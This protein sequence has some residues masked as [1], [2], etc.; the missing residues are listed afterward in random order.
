MGHHPGHQPGPCGNVAAL[1]GSASGRTADHGRR[2]DGVVLHQQR[3][4]PRVPH[5]APLLCHRP[6]GGAHGD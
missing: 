2:R 4:A 5:V 3:P 6:A 1:G